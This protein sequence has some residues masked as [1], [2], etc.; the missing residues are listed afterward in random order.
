MEIAK[1]QLLEMLRD[2]G[3]YCKAELVEQQLPTWVDPDQHAGQLGRIGIVPQ[4]ILGD[5]PG[6][7]G[8]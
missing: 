3:D 6:E 5:R 1:D 7:L 8:A 4:A 2:R